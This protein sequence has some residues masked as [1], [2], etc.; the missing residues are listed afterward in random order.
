M[1]KWAVVLG[2]AVIVLVLAGLYCYSL[3]RIEVVDARI[4]GVKDISLEGFTISW[5]A[6]ARN[7]NPTP[8]YLKKIEFDVIFNNKSWYHGEAE[9]F[10]VNAKSERVYVFEGPIEWNV[11]IMAMGGI[12]DS[13]EARVR[14]EGIATVADLGF[15]QIQVPFSD[16]MDIKKELT[17]LVIQKTEEIIGTGI[18]IGETVGSILRAGMDLLT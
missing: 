3:A 1:K 11:P 12:I 2:A 9:D 7:P 17:E 5:Q 14:V 13:G 18:D 4:T 8:V 6:T 15:T 10:K 16:D